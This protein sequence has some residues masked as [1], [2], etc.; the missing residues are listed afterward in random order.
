MLGTE[1]LTKG[2]I[3]NK[4]Q[5]FPFANMGFVN[6]LSQVLFYLALFSAF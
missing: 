3:I 4:L 6:S 2:L 1:S 5:H